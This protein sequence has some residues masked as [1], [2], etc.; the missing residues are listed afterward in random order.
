MVTEAANQRAAKLR[1]ELDA[2][3]PVALQGRARE[4][5]IN[6][7]Q[8][9]ATIAD[10]V[11]IIETTSCLSEEQSR[12]AGK[13]IVRAAWTA[14][15]HSCDTDSDASLSTEELQ[16]ALS[17][18]GIN[19][20]LKEL[21]SIK[22]AFDSDRNGKLDL[23]EFMLLLQDLTQKAETS[24]RRHF[25]ARAYCD[26][27]CCGCLDCVPYGDRT[28]SCDQNGFL[29]GGMLGPCGVSSLSVGGYHFPALVHYLANH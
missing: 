15:F 29:V 28:V 3:G 8:T 7:Q 9:D 17:Q 4:L 18:L 16:G 12:T 21:T 14:C 2:L 25:T 26:S 6:G 23:Q 11:T 27:I 1:F 10:T 24:G 20:Q 22:E 5:G 19:L 13:D